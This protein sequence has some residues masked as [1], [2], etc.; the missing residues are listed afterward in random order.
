MQ[1]GDSL[2]GNT[3]CAYG[4][5]FI[6]TLLLSLLPQVERYSGLKLFP[7]YSY[8]RMYKHGDALP[9][10]NDRL[11]CEISVTLCLGGDPLWPFWLEAPNGVVKVNLAPG[12]GL[13]YRGVE[14]AHWREAFDGTQLAQVFLHYVDTNGPNADWK[15]D[16]RKATS[17]PLHRVGAINLGT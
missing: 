1:S 5:P 10:H 17:S 9:K 2:L 13:L 14:C 7:T 4:D 16:R 11:A 12:D 15:F 8:F 6:D 3:P